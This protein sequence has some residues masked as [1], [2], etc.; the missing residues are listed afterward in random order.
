MEN[1]IVAPRIDIN[2]LVQHMNEELV[3]ILFNPNAFNAGHRSQAA[4]LAVEDIYID[5]VR[6][7]D[8]VDE[9]V[10][11]VSYIDDDG[12]QQQHGDLYMGDLHQHLK[13]YREDLFVFDHK[14]IK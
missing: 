14:R 10:Y 1:Y 11:G 13:V 12:V 5:S 6:T 7:I 3:L 4:W 9:E 2:K 8:G